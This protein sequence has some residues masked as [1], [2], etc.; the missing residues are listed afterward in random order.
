MLLLQLHRSPI[1]IKYEKYTTSDMTK[2]PDDRLHGAV[3][4]RL[5]I[6]TRVA[7]ASAS[8]A[9]AAMAD[10]VWM[11]EVIVLA[12]TVWRSSYEME[13]GGILEAMADLRDALTGPSGFPAGL[14]NV[15]LATF[16]ASIRAGMRPWGVTGRFRRIMAAPMAQ[17]VC[18]VLWAA[19]PHALERS[20]AAPLA[21]LLCR[22]LFCEAALRAMQSTLVQN[23]RLRIRQPTMWMMLARLGVA[24]FVMPTAHRLRL[25][26]SDEA[27]EDNCGLEADGGDG[28][29]RIPV[30]AGALASASLAAFVARHPDQVPAHDV[31]VWIRD[32]L[33]ELGL[34]LWRRSLEDP[35]LVARRFK[36]LEGA[37]Y[38]DRAALQADAGLARQWL[39]QLDE[40]PICM[41]DGVELLRLDCI[42][43]LLDGPVH[44]MCER[45]WLLLRSDPKR[46]PTC[47]RVCSAR[48][49]ALHPLHQA[50]PPNDES[51]DTS[52]A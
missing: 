40:C 25:F 24:H 52:Q 13:V 37:E 26:R 38:D 6:A 7:S 35:D 20:V 4:K 2:Q 9:W 33:M 44:A 28:G 23:R 16:P 18:V 32:R 45:C 46:C 3:L 30:I 49:F 22:E 50:D 1:G 51:A 12:K 43:D 27:L 29:D 39:L 31:Y 36:R 5:S 10:A 21:S 11:L 34:V 47:D 15:D 42:R 17:I 8:S 14:A 41:E 48:P 19:A